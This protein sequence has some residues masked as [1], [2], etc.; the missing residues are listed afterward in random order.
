M[1]RQFINFFFLG[2]SLLILWL[3]GNP[4]FAHNWI[5][6]KNEANTQNPIPQSQNSV[7]EGEK[8]FNNLCSYCHG[9]QAKGLDT[10]KTGLTKK[11]PN[12]LK[13]LSSHS[14]GDFHWKIRTGKGEMPPFE[15][16]V[17]ND[18]IWHI[19]NYLKSLK[20]N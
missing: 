3:S 9:K 18:E 16:E 2:I 5:A 4:S 13:R 11:T 12:L 17:L 6:P 10:S 14:D 15:N 7:N 19:I 8:L 20:N 1:K